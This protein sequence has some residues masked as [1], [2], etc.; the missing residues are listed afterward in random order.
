M[1]GGHAE[2]ALGPGGRSSW[3]ARVAALEG[4]FQSRA[5]TRGARTG[6]PAGDSERV[7]L[8]GRERSRVG[9]ERRA[10]PMSPERDGVAVRMVTP[11]RDGV[12]T[13]HGSPEEANG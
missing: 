7:C 4:A 1:D 13:T 12:T 9:I 10:I 11:C 3:P 8:N 2:A 5:G 6:L